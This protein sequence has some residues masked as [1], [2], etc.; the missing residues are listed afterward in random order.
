MGSAGGIVFCGVVF[1]DTYFHHSPISVRVVTAIL[2]EEVILSSKSTYYVTFLYSI[3]WNCKIMFV[4]WLLMFY[5]GVY[6]CK[7]NFRVDIIVAMN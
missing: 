4:V 6:T 3:H 5:S 2:Q 1:E 7:N